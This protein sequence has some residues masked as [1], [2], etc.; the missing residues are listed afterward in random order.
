VV[1]EGSAAFLCLGA[2]VFRVRETWWQVVLRTVVATT[3][4]SS[5][6]PPV[7]GDQEADLA[8]RGYPAP[9]SSD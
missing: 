9:S 4:G 7:L 1:S 6:S 3:A 2:L 5:W 8:P